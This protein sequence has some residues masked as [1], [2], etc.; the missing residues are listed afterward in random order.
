MKVYFVSRK[1]AALKLN[2]EFAGALDAFERSVNID[3]R[4]KM[5]AEVCPAGGLPASF[6]IDENL[7]SSPP[8]CMDVY[9]LGGGEALI[10]LRSF[11]SADM[12]LK[13]IFQTR[14]CDNLVTI[15]SQGEIY[16][17]VEGQK[18]FFCAIGEKF[19]KVAAEEKT[20]QGV[21]RRGYRLFS[22]FF[23]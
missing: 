13:I 15:F 12:R 20:V 9:L 19:S 7:L 22:I 21:K 2:G 16:L 18:Y 1:P 5:F 11:K 23:S 17:S 4:D 8:E 10:S 14:F 3:L 6:F